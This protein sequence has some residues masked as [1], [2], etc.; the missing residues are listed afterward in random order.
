MSLH[1][2]RLLARVGPPAP[3]F[4]LAMLPVTPVTSPLAEGDQR[5]GMP[6]FAGADLP[7]DAASEATTPG[8]GPAPRPAAP[9]PRQ[10]QQ[11][12]LVPP[13]ATP[14]AIGNGPAVTVAP[15]PAAER[16]VTSAMPTAHAVS[17]PD[18]A[19]PPDMPA[20]LAPLLSPFAIVPDD[21]EPAPRPVPPVE[22]LPQP[23]SAAPAEPVPMADTEAR[24]L[25]STVAPPM[26]VTEAVPLRAPAR[27]AGVETA[28]VPQVAAEPTHATATPALA[29]IASLPAAAAPD[30]GTPRS[31][32]I[33]E[34]VI[35][36][37]PP[38]APA[39]PRDLPSQVRDQRGAPAATP[40]SAEAAS[41][42]GPLPVSRPFA[43]LFGMRRR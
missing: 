23:V 30:T 22:P 7:L 4:A 38:P 41:I 16:P 31:V 17:P 27:A 36:V 26:I 19:V 8:E 3:G 10:P 25:P 20:A 12:R 24:V 37:V 29:P 35:D 15:T 34:V 33:E 14:E 9:I 5:I 21:F 43:T 2:Q 1:L 18:L 6:E 13:H 42:I 32:V 40:L 39:A 11:A 28:S